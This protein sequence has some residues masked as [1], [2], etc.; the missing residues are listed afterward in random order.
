MSLLVAAI[1]VPANGAGVESKVIGYIRELPP[2]S[3]R[4]AEARH[5]GSMLQSALTGGGDFV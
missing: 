3:A 5:H 4:Q 2:E 1:V